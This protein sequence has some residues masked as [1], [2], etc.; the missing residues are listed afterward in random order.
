MPLSVLD[1]LITIGVTRGLRSGPGV[2]TPPLLTE[3]FLEESSVT[4]FSAL[5]WWSSSS[6]SSASDS[7]PTSPSSGRN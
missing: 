4:R 2:L 5:M 1:L 3:F 7:K 6:S